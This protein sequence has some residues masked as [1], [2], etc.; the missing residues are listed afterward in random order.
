MPYEGTSERLVLVLVLI[1]K[2]APHRPERISDGLWEL[3]NACWAWDPS[4]RPKATSVGN[5]LG[6]LL[7]PLGGQH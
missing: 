1:K 3:L 2:Q 7:P 6:A 5:R 4:E